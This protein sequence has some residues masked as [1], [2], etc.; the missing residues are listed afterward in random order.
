MDNMS[1]FVREKLCFY[2]SMYQ[3]RSSTWE[4]VK[5]A[6][7]FG[8]AGVELMN[9]SDELQVPDMAVAKEVGAYM[10]S[11]GLVIPCFSAGI[12]LVGEDR[13]EKISN[14]KKYADICSELEIPY[15]HHTVA[16]R[17][18]VPGL[19]DSETVKRGL[20]ASV[21]I[22]EY[23]ERRGVRTIVEDQGFVFNGVEYYAPLM[24]AGKGKIGAL[25]DV[26]N[27]M[28]VDERAEDFLAAYEKDICHVHLKDYTISTAPHPTKTSY[29]TR[30]GSYLTDAEMGTGDVNFEKVRDGL[31]RMNYSGYYALEFS[32]VKDEDEVSRVI[33]RMNAVFS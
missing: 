24:S 19:P 12:N 5:T 32:G 30:G 17:F 4:I 13:H 3:G 6:E 28:F 1:N 8:V 29:M 22:N 11:A 23:A 14:L 25:L 31:R 2:S 26:G 15:L 9:F 10:K 27:I 21:E 18:D 16:F 33:S 7:R 20:D